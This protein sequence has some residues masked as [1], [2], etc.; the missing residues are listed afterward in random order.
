LLG[1]LL[2]VSA[3]SISA[4]FMLLLARGSRWRLPAVFALRNIDKWT[5]VLEILVLIAVVVSLGSVARV[6]LS[7]WGVLLLFGTVLLG[8]VVPLLLHRRPDWLG[9]RTPAIA[10]VLVL[11]GG[12]VLRTVVMVSPTEIAL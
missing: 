11:I 1:M 5:I 2:L 3:V 6:W 7:A 9:D 4:A 10:A 8:M 12:F